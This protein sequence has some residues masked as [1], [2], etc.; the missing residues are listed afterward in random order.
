MNRPNK[1]RRLPSPAAVLTVLLMMALGFGAGWLGAWMADHAD[2][3]GWQ[4]LALLA[5]A[6]V[7]VLV[8]IVLHEGGHL[9]AG[10]ATG[11][12]F[13]SFRIGSIMLLKKDG[14]LQ[15]CRYQLAGTGGQCLLAPPPWRE[16]GF[17]SL[18]Y[19]LGG[20][21][22]NLLSAALCGLGAWL[23]WQKVPL[24]AGLWGVWAMLGLYLG[25]VNGIPLKIQ[26]MPNDGYNALC[27][28]GDKAAQ[29]AIWA[30]L[31]I[32]TAQIEGRRLKDL[33]AEWFEL[34]GG[35][36]P[37]D[38]L[39][40]AVWVCRYSR[41]LDE[42]R[43]EDAAALRARLLGSGARLAAVHRYSL[44]VDQAFFQLTDRGRPGRPAGKTAAGLPQ[45]DEVASRH[46]AGPL[47]GGAGRRQNGGSRPAAQSPGQN[48]GGLAL[49][50]RRRVGPGAAGLGRAEAL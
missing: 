41:L 24:A 3:A 22:A 46:G 26:G 43:Y 44:E 23:C 10:L 35:A 20:P 28:R 47:R 42:G 19:N 12:G 38:P 9:A 2:L 29:R 32:N 1:K 7:G 39:K 6:A 18:L 16:E 36:G 25:L 14:R 13:V 45:A 11:Y 33:P 5:A 40:G 34:P 8:Q 15:F 17:P 49:R 4:L 27:L 48:A 50:R 30:Q 31:A 37:D 21:A